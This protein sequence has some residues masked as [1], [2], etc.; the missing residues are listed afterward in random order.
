M[1]KLTLLAVA[2]ILACVSSA[3][4]DEY[5]D[6]NQTLDTVLRNSACTKIISALDEKP[7]NIGPAYA[8]LCTMWADKNDLPSATLACENANVLYTQPENYVNLGSVEFENG[9][10][11]KALAHFESALIL[12]PSQGEAVFNRKVALDKLAAK[13]SIANAAPRP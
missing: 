7:E 5:Q 2:A 3:H 11:E 9:S 1:R 12:N 8:H 10:Y 6:C 4:A 13:Q